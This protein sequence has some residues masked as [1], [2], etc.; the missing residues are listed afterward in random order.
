MA[1]KSSA[2]KRSSK[3]SGSTKNISKCPPH[4]SRS[5]SWVL[6]VW[7]SDRQSR[8]FH[9]VKV[10]GEVREGIWQDAAGDEVTDHLHVG[11]V[12]GQSPGHG[13]IVRT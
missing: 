7:K 13:Q 6:L 12:L 11:K 8:L 10:V 9:D 3:R 2:I 1:A 4:N 5:Y